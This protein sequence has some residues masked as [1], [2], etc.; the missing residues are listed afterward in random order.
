MNKTL[1]I[2]LMACSLVTSSNIG[3]WRPGNNGSWVG[4]TLPTACDTLDTL[5]HGDTTATTVNVRVLLPCAVVPD[6]VVVRWGRGVTPTDSAKI[7]TTDSSQGDTV[8]YTITGL[9]YSDS[10]YYDFW[11]ETFTTPQ[12]LAFTADSVVGDTVIQCVAISIDSI[13]GP[14]SVQVGGMIVVDLTEGKSAGQTATVG[15]VSATIDYESDTLDTIICPS[16]SVGL[17]WVKIVDSCRYADSVQIMVWSPSPPP[18]YTVNISVTNGTSD[19]SGANS[20]DSNVQFI[21][22]HA[23]NIHY[24]LTGITVTGTADTVW[25]SATE[26][27]ITPHSNCDVEIIYGIDTFTLTEVNDGNGTVVY[28]PDAEGTSPRSYNYGTLV[29]VTATPNTGYAFVVWQGGILSSTTAIDSVYMLDHYVI[30]PVWGLIPVIDSVRFKTRRDVALNAGRI[31]DTMI[32]Y[33]DVDDSGD[34][35]AIFVGAGQNFRWN[36]LSWS[37]DGT[38]DSI[39]VV[40]PPGTASKY[41]RVSIRNANMVMSVLPVSFSCYIKTA[42]R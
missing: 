33:A 40:I 25:T 4:S 32:V 30:Q 36:H 42:G 1:F 24:H 2:V 27:R 10:V 31:G 18:V 11:L 23:P 19:Q 17:R 12:Q 26:F 20:V 41:F 9:I 15:G 37:T 13:I 38:K 35:S 8:K 29:H 6:S 5:A 39:L 16:V 22:G 3:S 7:T 14:D 21:V 28:V 34:S